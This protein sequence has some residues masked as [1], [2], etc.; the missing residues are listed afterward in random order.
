MAEDCLAL[1]VWTPR[2]DA[3]QRPVMVWI[4]GGGFSAG[5]AR[6]TWYDGA[7]L[8]GR[9]DVVVVSL[10]YRLGAWGFLELSQIGGEHFLE[11]GNV[12]LLDQIA[13]LKWVKQ[14]I[15]AFGGDS[16]NVTLFGQSAGSA[17]AGILM[18]IPAAQGLFRK[19]I[20]ESGAPKEVNDKARAN[21]VSQAYLK[22]AGASSPD[23]I[24]L[25]GKIFTS[26][27][28]HPYVQALAIR[29]ERIFA[30]GNVKDVIALAGPQTKRVELGGRVVIP[31]INDAHYHCDAEPNAFHLQ[32]HGMDPKWSEV[33]DQLAVAE[34]KAP[35]EALIIGDIGPTALDDPQAT[36]TSLDK[37]VP[38]HPVI[39][40][41]WSR[42]AAVVNRPGLAKLGVKDDEPDPLGG[43]FLRSPDSAK[44]TGVA[45]EYAA[46]RLHQA[47]TSLASE[48]EALQQMR[49]FLSDAARLGITS[50]Q[51]MS[52]PAGAERCVGLLE[53]APTPIRVRVMRMAGTTSNARDTKEGRSLPRNP[54][55]LITVSGTKWVLDGSPIESSA[56]MRKPYAD[57]SKG[58]GW[59]NFNEKEMEAMLRE[60]LEND[61][62]LLAHVVGD[63][64]TEAFL[65]AME[66]TG[67]KTVWEKRR[68][69]IEHGD[70]VMPDLMS[71][72]NGLGVVVVENPTH[73]TIRELMV[74]RYG[75][76][77]ADEM[78]PL[79]SLLDAGIP[80]AFGSDG[81]NNP[82]LNI[83]L[84]SIYPGKPKE[85]LTREQAVI[86]YTLTSAYAEFAEKDK[87]SLERGKLADLAVLSQD[88]F[89]IPPQDLPKTESVLTLVGGKVVYD[90]HAVRMQ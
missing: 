14:N 85:A 54:T 71:R 37:L 83:M 52:L 82:Y 72:A 74:K 63:R 7:T 34:T 50:V 4:H 20:M 62:Q 45:F 30:V 81:P 84:A 28:A 47:V 48:G 69:R 44:L 57:N 5:S 24:L 17:S 33:A 79:R 11:S 49:A 75:L 8:A 59:L 60:S 55:P 76:E 53:K 64:T 36:G 66:A 41:T 35:K 67:G 88:I 61:D 90:A 70:G 2:A 80:V 86:A 25:N 42:H 77:R 19:A 78:Q 21:D 13:A 31:G 9:G 43:R 38:N 16:N 15:A 89:T 6:N 26:D 39:L 23:M 12:G 29:G 1:N 40:R 27:S 10:Q 73:L 32:F 51:D 18:L 68:V 3:K 65:T 56:A 58:S 22:I 46:F 87:G